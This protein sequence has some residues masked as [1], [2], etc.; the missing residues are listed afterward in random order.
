MP[1]VD[2]G[3]DRHEFDRRH[4]E[5]LQMIEDGRRFQRPQGTAIRL[6]HVGM[7]DRERSDRQF[8]DQAAGLEERRPFGSGIGKSPHNGL[9]HERGGIAALASPCGQ[10]RVIDVRPVDLDRV[11]IDQQL[12]GIE[13]LALAGIIRTVGAEAVAL[14]GFQA[15]H[16]KCVNTFAVRLQFQSL[17][18]TF[19][20]EQAGPDALRRARPDGE[21]DTFR[22]DGCAEGVF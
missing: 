17:R 19:A 8:V 1:L 22:G 10:A 14:A 16:E 12:V 21:M 15:W 2:P 5:L 9:G 20:I 11:G 6:R 18:L 4:A 13:P 7:A 3:C